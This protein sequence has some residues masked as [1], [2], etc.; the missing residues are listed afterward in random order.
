MSLRPEMVG[1]SWTDWL[2][3]S[4]DPSLTGSTS[5]DSNHSNPSSGPGSPS[6]A[7]ATAA[8]AAA[9]TSSGTGKAD[10]TPNSSRSH[11]PRPLTPCADDVMKLP[12][13]DMHIFGLCPVQVKGIYLITFALGTFKILSKPRQISQ[14][15]ANIQRL[16]THS[17]RLWLLEAR[18]SKKPVL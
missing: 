10:A 11:S 8:G 2:S 3:P 7:A 16:P 13:K 14:T 4:V 12:K 15:I 18:I 5:N 17:L 9:G 6:A 1:R